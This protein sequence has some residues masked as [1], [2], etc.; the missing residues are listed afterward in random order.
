MDTKERKQTMYLLVEEWRNGRTDYDLFFTM[1]D[2]KEEM[3]RIIK[4]YEEPDDD[5]QCGDY[6]GRTVDECIEDLGYRNE[7]LDGDTFWIEEVIAH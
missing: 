4:E 1:E 2:A 7:C 6:D 3:R 5:G